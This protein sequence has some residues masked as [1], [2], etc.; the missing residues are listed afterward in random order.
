MEPIRL[1]NIGYVHPVRSQTIYHTVAHMMKPSSPDTIILVSPEIPYV[2]VGFHQQADREVDLE[3]CEKEGLQVVRR[4]VGGGATYLDSNQVFVQWIFHRENLPASIEDRFSLYAKPLVE[5]YRSLGV[6]AYYRPV[7]DIHVAGKK[8]GGTGA[9][10]IGIS[11][12]VVGSLMFDFDKA[13]M[14]RVLKVSSE[15]M[16]DKIYSSLEQYMTTLHELLGSIPDRKTVT[17]IYLEKCSIALNRE[18]SDG[19]W[20]DDEENAAQ[21][22]DGIFATSEWLHQ[23]GG[24]RQTGVKIHQDVRVVE[25]DYKSPGGLI[26]V[27]ARLGNGRI[28]DISLTG[29]FTIIP[30]YSLTAIEHS[31]RGILVQPGSLL[32][33]IQDLYAQI[34]IV[35]PGV[36]PDDISNA[37]VKATS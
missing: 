34:G 26:R 35:S 7:N 28:D 3:Y 15:K 36:T 14:S 32:S 1:L 8:I 18:I 19:E 16:R 6:D 4:E 27:I 5:T 17:D 2:S 37:I 30:G 23:K 21:E 31:L 22:M 13:T 24:L 12:V 9:A 29:D 10:Q 11:E 33:R 20:T 25:T